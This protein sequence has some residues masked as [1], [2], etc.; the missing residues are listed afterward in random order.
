MLLAYWVQQ[1]AVTKEIAAVEEKHL[2]IAGSL[3]RAFE[4]YA[5]DTKAVF[6]HAS[7]NFEMLGKLRNVDLL[8][9]SMGISELC[10]VSASGRI[11]GVLDPNGRCAFDLDE[12]KIRRLRKKTNDDPG[13]VSIS[14]LRRVNDRPAFYLAH[15]IS[16]DGMV[17]GTLETNYLIEQQKSIAFGER[18]HSMVVD[19]VGRVVAHPNAEW[20]A[21]SKDASQLSVVQKMMRGETGVSSFYSPPMQADMIAG[22]TVV[23]GVGWGVMV[24]QPLSELLDQAGDVRGAAFLIA[25]T[26]LALAAFLGWLAAR[27]LASPIEAVSHT[28]TAIARGNDRARVTNIPTHTAREVKE[29]AKSFNQMV[30]RLSTTHTDL[31]RH[32][33]NLEQLVHERTA[34]LEREVKVR[35]HAEEV[36]QLQ[37]E[38]LDVT[39]ASIGDGVITSDSANNINYL[40]PVAEK[41]TGWSLDEARGRTLHGVLS[42]I[43]LHSSEPIELRPSDGITSNQIFDGSLLR[44]DESSMDVQITVAKIKDVEGAVTGLVIVVRDVTETR[45]LSQRLSYEASHDALTGLFNRRAFESRVSDAIRDA[46]DGDCVY[47]LCYIDLDQFKIVNDTCG[48]AAGDELLRAVTGLIK[49]RMR[50]SDVLA[51]LGGDEFGILFNQCSLARALTLAEGIRAHVQEFRFVYD[52]HSFHVGVSIGVVEISDAMTSLGEIFKSA[53]TACYLAKE[54]GRNRV[55]PFH[56]TDVDTLLRAGEVHWISRLRAA[57]DHHR[58]ELHAQAVAPLHEVANHHTHYEVLLRL[59][60][61][62]NQLIYP[63]TFLPAA[64]RYNLVPTIDRWVFAHAI[65]WLASNAGHLA[66]GRLSINLTGA[67][68]SEPNFLGYVQGQLDHRGLSAESIIIEITEN[69]AMSNLPNALTFMSA[70]KEDG[71]KF[72]LDDFGTGFSSLGTLKSLPVDYV[73]IDGGFV[74]DILTDPVD[75][76]MVNT[77]CEIGHTMNKTVVAE[78]VESNA[79]AARL[80]EIGVDYAQGFAIQKPRPLDDIASIETVEN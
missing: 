16:G 36:L 42:L 80:R 58:F 39:L 14:K 17:V 46:S 3:S 18:G 48:H 71:C 31:Q 15:T 59:R 29:L 64:A 26:G 19:A 1:T 68:L 38:N 24:P 12:D 11:S 61:D 32:R 43:D 74:R 70:L 50:K 28:A 67:T 20:E 25:A 72:A 4:R 13:K 2:I 57:L 51:R 76:K 56:P 6:A 27:F 65:A 41:L 55:E 63:S 5:N 54:R 75:D 8:L 52:D 44:R 10:S 22:H 35:E 73:K 62:N 49:Q 69:S 77:I 40:N 9:N 53:D 33:D 23:P 7:A 78:F 37:K 34:E 66:G 47:S 21:S 30:D 60:D 79:V 45:K